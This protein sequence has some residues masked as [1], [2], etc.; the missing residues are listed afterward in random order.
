[1][2][3]YYRVSYASENELLLEL[4]L[5]HLHISLEELQH[6][7]ELQGL[8]DTGNVHASMKEW[9]GRKTARSAVWHAG[10]V[11]RAT[12]ELPPMHL[13]DFYAISLFHASLTFWAFGLAS[14]MFVQDRGVTSKETASSKNSQPVVYL[15][16]DET[17]ATYRYISLDIGTPALHNPRHDAPLTPLSDISGVMTIIIEMMAQGDGEPTMP[18]SPLVENLLNVMGAVA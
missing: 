5:M 7:C 4:I 17:S 9:V 11:I 6:F 16:D 14:R 10:Q 1:M 3:D 12:R 2:F 8:E 18:N 15:D 13:R